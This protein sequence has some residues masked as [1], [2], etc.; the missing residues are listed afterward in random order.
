M[1]QAEPRPAPNRSRGEYEQPRT[2]PD[3]L[4]HDGC[5]TDWRLIIDLVLSLLYAEYVPIDGAKKR[6]RR[7]N[8]VGTG[9]PAGPEAGSTG[10][11]DG[12]ENKVLDINSTADDAS[13]SRRYGNHT[14]SESPA[15][16]VSHAS[17]P[18]PRAVI[19][20]INALLCALGI[21]LHVTLLWKT[22][23]SSHDLRRFT[24]TL[25]R[26]PVFDKVR[27]QGGADCDGP[28]K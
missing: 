25:R 15:A 27:S 1:R 17:Y 5:G 18:P 20:T 7:T 4:V 6:R 12:N 26:T 3:A 22:R 19:D 21:A 16:R 11:R 24:P 10:P 13:A 28:R 14:A 23:V 9:N 2:L 8:V